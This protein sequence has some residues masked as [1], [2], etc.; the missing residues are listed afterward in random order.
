MV[1]TGDQ[2]ATGGNQTMDPAEPKDEPNPSLILYPAA[3]TQPGV[4]SEA[5]IKG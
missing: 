3:A 5:G 4:R 2:Q 1:P